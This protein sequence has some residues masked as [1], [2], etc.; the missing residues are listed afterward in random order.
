MPDN[1]KR[2]LHHFAAMLLTGAAFFAT[3]DA[4]TA[5]QPT[6][7]TI[8]V[9]GGNLS[10][11]LNALAT[12][13]RLQIVYDAAITRGLS[14]AGVSGNLAVDAALS[15]LLSGTGIR[16]RVNG[17]T[18]TLSKPGITDAAAA[19]DADATNLGEISVN[20]NNR[21]GGGTPS[22]SV[23]DKQAISRAQA[24]SLPELVARTPGVSMG[25]GVRLQGQ[26]ISIRGFSR[27]SDTRILLDGAP[28]NFEKYDQGTVFVEPELLKRVEIDKGATSVRYGNGGFGGT[29]RMESKD[30]ADMLRPGESWGAYGKTAYQTANKQFLETG[31]LY[32]RS[33]F[34][35]PVTYDGLLSLTWRKGDDM[36]I[37]GG[38]HYLYSDE[39]LTS[40]MGKFGAEF[41]GHEFKTSILYG[42]SNNWGPV[43]A[44]RGQIDPIASDIRNYGYH[45]AVRRR[46]AWR[47]LKDLTAT[48]DYKFDGDSELWNPHFMASYSKT[49][50]HATRPGD[51]KPSASVGGLENDAAYSDIH[52][53]L[54][55]TSDFTLG[56]MQHSLNYGLQFNAHKRDISMFDI[57]NSTRPDYNYGYYAP[58][59]MPEGTQNTASAFIRDTISLTDSLSL[60][61]GLRFDWVR[62]EGVP[63]AA[64]R[65]NNPALGHDYSAVDHKGFTPAVS[66]AWT[67]TSNVRFFA[68][69]AYAMRAPNID[70]LYSTQGTSTAPATSRELQIERNNTINLG[71]DFNFDDVMTSGDAL[72]TRIAVFNNHVTN[73][74]G[75]RFGGR[76]LSGMGAEGVDWYWNMPSYYTS[77]VEVQAHYD[78]DW[79]FADLGLSIMTGTR[80]GAINDIRGPRTYVNDL[81][82]TT[83]NLTL[84]M[85]MPDQ[86]LSFGWSGTFVKSQEKTPIR[87]YL[88]STYARPESP[89]YAVHTV[90]LDWTPKDGIMKDTELHAA[91]ENIFDKN[92]EPYLGD[93]I[94]AMPGRNFKISLSRKF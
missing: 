61:P 45:E 42:E 51:Q 14:T 33:D 86:D 70:E 22:T 50:Q 91:V 25:G 21:Y 1:S 88:G 57:A 7:I 19:T 38:E 48:F 79:M 53:E 6:A 60:T 93:G 84:G 44:I 16:Y 67:A 89:G 31:A 75:R 85:K 46:L 54:E 71:V 68:D 4:A 34:G 13:A 20:T 77:G 27:Q 83:T 78:N 80:H 73:P 35:T 39:K 40:G 66:L 32:G 43:A 72:S 52:L 37:G 92:Y 26:T 18:V 15:Q 5:Q 82:P 8:N 62:S 24:A 29:I 12:Q 28:K 9:P 90:F 23:I 47:E 17:K 10:S 49:S 81:A 87:Q 65:Y 11:A 3:V 2:R 58:Y 76:N 69:W 63:N 94:A 56:G 36:R 59:F 30:A 41:D 64:P 74:V 55:N